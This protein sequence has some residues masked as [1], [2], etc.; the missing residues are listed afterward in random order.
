MPTTRDMSQAIGRGVEHAEAAAIPRQP[1]RRLR[2]A[3]R[4]V[5]L[6]RQEIAGRRNPPGP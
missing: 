5:A 3:L 2:H 4:E 1:R 6:Q